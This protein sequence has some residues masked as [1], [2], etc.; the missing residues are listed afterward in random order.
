MTQKNLNLKGW[1]MG[2]NPNLWASLFLIILSAAVISEAL[3]L[4]V[5]TPTNPGSGFMIF[6]VAAVLGLLALHQLIKSLRSYKP[7]SEGPAE[8]IHWCRITGVILSNAL[9]IYLLQVV[10]YLAC[11]FLLLFFLFQV[12]ERGRWVPRLI[13]AALTS[14]FTYLLFAWLLQLNLP[15]GVIP[16]F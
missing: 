3:E 9:Y 16:F 5:G 15:K 10:G 14:L 2:K 1:V 6:G 7:K 4:E 13:G 12:L 11:T 8:K